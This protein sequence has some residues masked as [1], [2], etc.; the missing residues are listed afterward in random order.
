MHRMILDKKLSGLV[1]DLNSHLPFQGL[2]LFLSK[3]FV[4]LSLMTIE[5]DDT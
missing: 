3:V 2:T 4:K 1:T 5:L